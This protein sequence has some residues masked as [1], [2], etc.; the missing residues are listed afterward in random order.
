MAVEYKYG[1]AEELVAILDREFNIKSLV[2]DYAAS[3]QGKPEEEKER[4]AQEVFGSYGRNLARRLL[5]LEGGY[6]DRNAE[7]I[8]Q[9]AQTTGLIFP[10]VPQ[11]LL[12]IA[13]LS[14]RPEDDWEYVE[15][16]HKRLAYRVKSCSI[17]QALGDE[18]TALPCKH[19]CLEFF[20]S[21][22]QGLGIP[23]D[24]RMV[25]ELPRDYYCQFDALRWVLA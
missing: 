7:L 6:R 13:M 14:S 25:A 22:F 24:L 16:S 3:I 1:L 19:A 18:A 20:H 23:V 11:R 9:V 5:E 21:L 4:I 10:S 2:A 8:Y 17:N 15:T 12:E